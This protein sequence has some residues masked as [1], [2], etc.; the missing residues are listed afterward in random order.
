MCLDDAPTIPKA[1]QP[2]GPWCDRTAATSGL[3][4]LFSPAP[5]SPESNPPPAAKPRHAHSPV[6]PQPVPKQRHP[7]G[8][9]PQ[10]ASRPARSHVPSYRHHQSKSPPFQYSPTSS[11][12]PHHAKE[13][14]NAEFTPRTLEPIHD[15]RLPT[16]TSS[17]PKLVPKRPSTI[18]PRILSPI[19]TVFLVPL[20]VSLPA[21]KQ[22]KQGG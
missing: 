21:P 8:H 2:P 14:A 12:T 3:R 20:P 16:I 18:P 15:S 7:S 13:P 22:N 4:R 10:Q 17:Q 19:A 6:P 1:T 5:G 11:L 9:Q